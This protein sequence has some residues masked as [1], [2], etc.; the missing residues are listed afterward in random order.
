MNFDHTHN[1]PHVTNNEYTLYELNNLV[2]SVL[3]KSLDEEY[4]VVGEL[5]DASQG[6]G[7]HFYGELI[8]KE[9]DGKRILARARVTCWAG[10]ARRHEGAAAGEGHL[11]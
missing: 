7:G 5:S 1:S 11:P 6:Y 3:E 9:G 8:E 2:R 10:A 4:W